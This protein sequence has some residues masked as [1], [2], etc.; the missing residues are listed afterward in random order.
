MTGSSLSGALK[1]EEKEMVDSHH[2]AARPLMLVADIGGTNSRFAL[3]EKGSAALIAPK[4]YTNRDFPTLHDAAMT[5]LAEVGLKP[6][7]ACIAVACPVLGD[8]V[9]LTN[10]PVWAFSQ[11]ELQQQLGVQ[12][13]VTIN[14]FSALAMAIPQLDAQ[15]L[16]QVG[17]GAPL[18]HMPMVVL[19]PGTGLGVSGLLWTGKHYVPLQGEGGHVNFAPETDREIEILKIGRREHDGFF[20]AENALCGSGFAFLYKALAEIEGWEETSLPVEEI[21]RRA[22]E[23]HCPNCVDVI[24]TFCGLLGSFSGNLALTLGA[25]GGVY[26]G[27]GIIP[28][29]GMLFDHSPFRSRFEGKGRFRNYISPIPTYVIQSHMHAALLGSVAVLESQ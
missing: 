8:H 2:A 28:R 12:R 7:A 27:G 29:F 23:S 17:G 10:Y 9:Q 24:D 22:V 14:D 3:C 13:L 20:S 26:I 25:F 18:K 19:G 11:H 5:Y 16:H 21:T 1:I 6:E 15:E 4:R